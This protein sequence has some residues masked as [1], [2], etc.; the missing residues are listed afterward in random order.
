MLSEL[1]IRSLSAVPGERRALVGLLDRQFGWRELAFGSVDRR[2]RLGY[3]T[4]LRL[5]L[6]LLCRGKWSFGVAPPLC[7][8]GPGD[9]AVQAHN[10]HM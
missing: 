2:G 9:S 7:V 6:A 4:G 1:E 3:G 10:V 8:D 5:F